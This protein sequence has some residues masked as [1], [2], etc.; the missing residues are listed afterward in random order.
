MSAIW[1]KDDSIIECSFKIAC[2]CLPILVLGMMKHN[3]CMYVAGM[4]GVIALAVS[5][6]RILTIAF[7][8][9]PVILNWLE[10]DVDEILVFP[11]SFGL[12]SLLVECEGMDE[13]F[14][15]VVF[16]IIIALLIVVCNHI[17]HNK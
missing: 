1:K 2:A 5:M 14:Y 12:S 16:S 10:K 13:A 7:N 11:Y 9:K 4:V 8:G 17:G 15:G 3:G 6:I